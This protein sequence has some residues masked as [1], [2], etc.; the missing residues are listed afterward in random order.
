MCRI[1][2]HPERDN[3]DSALLINTPVEAI[4]AYYELPEEDIQ[5][6]RERCSSYTMSMDEF[7][8]MVAKEVAGS[9]ISQPLVHPESLQRQI[10]LREADYLTSVLQEYMVTLKSTGREIQRSLREA[11]EFNMPIKH[12]LGQSLVD[13]YLGCGG[14]VR[15]TVKTLA[16]VSKQLKEP[17]LQELAE[18]GI[19]QVMIVGRGATV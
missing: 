4:A 3:I 13:L 16:D 17:S 5:K 11:R 14:E 2:E 8:A 15:Q 7:D 9:S 6:H 12:V 18:A 10:H 19:P 1:C